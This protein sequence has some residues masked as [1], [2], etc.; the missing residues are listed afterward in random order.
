M[1]FYRMSLKM[2]EPFSVLGMVLITDRQ[3]HIILH[4]SFGFSLFLLSV[5]G[6][7]AYAALEGKI[8]LRDAVPQVCD[9][10]P[11]LNPSQTLLKYPSLTLPRNSRAVVPQTS[12]TVFSLSDL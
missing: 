3:L 10:H 7:F 2:E 9:P 5:D 1:L 6:N 8:D 4:R 11:L 12:H